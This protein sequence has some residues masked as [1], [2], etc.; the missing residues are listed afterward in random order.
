MSSF[1][2]AA[3]PTSCPEA[4]AGPLDR[5]AARFVLGDMEA[6]AGGRVTVVL[7]DGSVRRFGDAGGRDVR[8]DVLSWRTFRRL[9]LGGDC[10]AAE[11]YMDGDWRTDDLVGVVSLF[12][13]NAGRFDRETPLT[14]ATTLWNRV[15]HAARRNTLAGSRR[16]VRS[17]YDLGND[18]YRLFLDEGMTYSCALFSRPGEDLEEA[19]ERKFRRIE[20]LGGLGPGQRILEIGCGWGGFA[21]HAARRFGC[22][23][24]GL[25]LSEEQ[26]AWAR[27]RVRDEGLSE[28]VDVRLL[29]YRSLSA[30]ADGRFDRIV[31]IEM[32]EAV[33]HEY[34]GAFFA[35]CDEMLRPGGLAVL[36]VIT[37]PDRRHDRLL[38]RPDFIQKHVFPGSHVPSI[39]A[40]AAAA[41][42][43]SSLFLGRVEE[44]GPHY[45]ETLRRWRLRFSENRVRAARLGYDERFLRMWEYYLAYCE[46]GFLARHVNDV[47]IVLT[48]E[49]TPDFAP[50]AV[51]GG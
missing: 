1:D 51:Y 22:H 35:K 46:G 43:S 16:N 18:F 6:L 38:R 30:A 2:S 47:Q 37:I 21:V 10:G 40:I 31:S 5:L 4:A 9:L 20:E 36:Q 26:A 32:L 12:V 7:P 3:E 27:Q 50:A 24:T 34:L 48:R 29:D 11:A 19:Q 33:G 17:H 28:R 13:G 42:R 15:R 49:G 14:R 23:V 45:A 39:S 25:T 44:I 41:A 8:V